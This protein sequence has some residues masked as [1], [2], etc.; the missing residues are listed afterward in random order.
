MFANT[1]GLG[2]RTRGR[3]M[4]LAVEPPEDRLEDPQQMKQALKRVMGM[5][6]NIT[7]LDAELAADNDV[8]RGSALAGDDRKTGPFKSSYYAYF[9]ITVAI[10]CLRSLRALLVTKET[11]NHVELAAG[12]Y[13]PYALVRNSLDC[14]AM[15]IWLLAPANR[16]ERVRRRLLVEAN[17]AHNA[18]QARATLG[19]PFED[20]MGRRRS[21]TEEIADAAG[22]EGFSDSKARLPTMTE[23]LTEVGA[24]EDSH[25]L[26]PLGTWQL[27]SGMAHGKQWASL[28]LNELKEEERL[29]DESAGRYRITISFTN[30]SLVLANTVCLI[31]VAVSLYEDRRADHTQQERRQSPHRALGRR[32]ISSC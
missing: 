8:S 10:Q 7:Q 9:Q 27:A 3:R 31:G 22:I 12:P 25:D 32:P 18:K 6:D 21:R 15:A 16:L 19:L 2:F 30:L 5:L 14:A 17:E 4:T 13:G 20:V 26:H 29:P 11:E 23:I 24:R 1:V 28:A